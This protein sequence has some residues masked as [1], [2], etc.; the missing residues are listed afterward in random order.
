AAREDKRVEAAH[1]RM[2]EAADRHVTR[3]V[4]AVLA[5]PALHTGPAAV[6]DAAARRKHRERRGCR[7]AVRVADRGADR[8]A[9]AAAVAGR[10]ERPGRRLQAAESRRGA[11]ASATAGPATATAAATR[12]DRQVVGDR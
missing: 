1:V 11:V 10:H 9:G 8:A 6:L 2:R 5:V 4:R 12:R 7:E 3:A